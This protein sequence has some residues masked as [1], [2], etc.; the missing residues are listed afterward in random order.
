[1]SKT[2]TVL[3]F[4]FSSFRTHQHEYTFMESEL[5]RAKSVRANCTQTFLALPRR[6]LFISLLGDGHLAVG[7]LRDVVVARV[8]VDQLLLAPLGDE[9]G[10][11]LGVERR[12]REEGLLR[13][14]DVGRA[15]VAVARHIVDRDLSHRLAI[16]DEQLERLVGVVELVGADVD[17]RVVRGHADVLGASRGGQRDDLRRV[18]LD[19]LAEDVLLVVVGD[20]LVGLVQPAV[21]AA[22]RVAERQV[23]LDGRATEAAGRERVERLAV[24]AVAHLSVAERH[25]REIHERLAGGGD[26]HEGLLDTSHLNV[27]LGSWVSVSTCRTPTTI[28]IRTLQVE[29]RNRELLKYVRVVT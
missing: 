14:L 17:E 18:E 11:T 26:E 1:M 5:G 4:A 24:G 3:Y 16:T 7:R 8:E 10:V 28:V 22:V 23:V 6:S 15:A 13:R 2:D 27:S 9:L 29:S 20:D 21:D 19:V 25:V 12:R